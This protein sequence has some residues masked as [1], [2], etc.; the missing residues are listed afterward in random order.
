MIGKDL[1]V[2]KAFLEEGKTVAIPTE[3]VYGL[4]ANALNPE[5]VLSIF[6]IKNRPHFDPLIIHTHAISEFE[7]YVSS[8]PK[9]LLR[10]VEIFSPGPITLLLPKK[11]IIPD[12]VTSGLEKVAIRI[13][14]HPLTLQLLRSIDFPLAAPSANPF[15]YVSPT[16]AE[17]VNKQLGDKIPY[18]LDGGECDIG[19]EST[20]VGMEGDDIVVYRLG[21]L[22][23]E[24]IEE[25][26]GKV[27][28]QLNQSS[29]PAAPGM[30]KSHYAPRIP[31]IITSIQEYIQTHPQQKIGVI[32]FTHDYTSE[33]VNCFRLSAD[34]NLNEAAQNLF[35]ALR[36]FDD[37]NVEIIVAENLPDS[38]LGRAVND[39]LKRAAAH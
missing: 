28:V 16:T 38:F 26:V 24:A 39:R 32:S 34:G 18:I 15:G 8:I 23:I 35:T 25:V 21:G 22:S 10:L 1:Q 13:P 5:A 37:T 20:I 31:L 17:H 33:H 19:L 36:S 3:T 6:Q 11:N 12:I 7:K 9:P 14:N 27:T 30:L 4:A 2:A 29:N